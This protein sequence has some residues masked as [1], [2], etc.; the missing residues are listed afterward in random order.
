MGSGLEEVI[1]TRPED[2][3]RD[4][5]TVFPRLGEIYDVTLDPIVGSEIGELRPALV[6]SNDINNEFADTVT[7]APLTGQPSRRTYPFDVVVPAGTAGLTVDSRIKA[8]QIRT[9]DKRR[10][11][12][13]RGALP[14]HIIDE[15]KRAIKVHLALE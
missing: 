14:A 3:D 12:Q 1:I 8:N 7:V 4:P 15:V 2:R 11:V 9:V 10:L 6:V 13:R 5:R